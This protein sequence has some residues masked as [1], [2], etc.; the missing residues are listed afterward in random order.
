MLLSAVM[1]HAIPGLCTDVCID[2]SSYRDPS[3][4]TLAYVRIVA[5][6]GQQKARG[7]ANPGGT[8]ELL[9]TMKG[10]SSQ[11]ITSKPVDEKILMGICEGIQKLNPK[12][13]D[14]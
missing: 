13:R 4:I 1:A 12:F 2:H 8:Q 11:E 9:E 6:R 10:L 14:K 3:S 7:S 5:T